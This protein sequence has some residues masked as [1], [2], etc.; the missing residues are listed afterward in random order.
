MTAGS[1]SLKT[2]LASLLTCAVVAF[3]TAGCG[4]AVT[5][6]EQ[7]SK[8]WQEQ[9]SDLQKQLD[10]ANETFRKES[11]EWRRQTDQLGNHMKVAAD[12][13]HPLVI[14]ELFRDY[15]TLGQ[16]GGGTPRRNGASSKEF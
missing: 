13:I 11:E 5:R 9:A 4:D 3:G 10:Q 2:S 8:H 7:Q 16:H 14:K 6:L 1:R 15:K 12:Q